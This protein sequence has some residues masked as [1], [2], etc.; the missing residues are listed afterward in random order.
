MLVKVF[1][2]G[3]RILFISSFLNQS[4]SVDTVCSQH[5]LLLPTE[6][7]IDIDEQ[8]YGN[9]ADICSVGVLIDDHFSKA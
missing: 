9:N 3:F 7:L 2:N 5:M 8:K 4:M 6:A 1:A